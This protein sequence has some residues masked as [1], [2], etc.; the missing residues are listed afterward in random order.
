MNTQSLK[1]FC[2]SLSKRI[3]FYATSVFFLSLIV[4]LWR[5]GEG[6]LQDWDEAIYAE[7]SKNIVERNNWVTLFWGDLPWFHKP[8]LFMWST[9]ALFEIFG[10]SEF[11]A[12]AAS[13]ISGI[14]LVVTTYFLG[15]KIHSRQAG[16]LAS[17]I[18]LSSKQIIFSSRFGTTDIML[19]LFMMFS[20]YAYI[21]AQD[22][23]EHWL[24]PM[25]SA[26]ALAFMV[27]G[28]ASVFVPIAIGLL[29]VARK[30]SVK[31]L[32]S[33]HFWVGLAI[34]A[35]LVLPWHLIM[36]AQHGS[37]FLGEYIGYHVIARATQPLEGH[38]HG[39]LFYVFI[40]RNQ[41]FPWFFLVLPAVFS[42]FLVKGDSKYRKYSK[43][44]ILF[45][46]IV[47]FG[48]T[49]AGTKLPWYIVP[50]Y[51]PLAILVA[52]L[53]ICIIR[54]ERSKLIHYA[55]L[56]I[57]SGLFLLGLYNSKQIYIPPSLPIVSIVEASNL[58]SSSSPLN[59][60]LIY[61]PTPKFYSE[62]P[63]NF[64]WDSASLKDKSLCDQEIILKTE[65]LTDLEPVNFSVIYE[66][67]AYRLIKLTCAREA[68][69]IRQTISSFQ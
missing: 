29:I 38:D 18:L 8:P 57:T 12:R 48:Y 60:Y 7:V 33:R 30:E 58:E 67:N 19:T 25:F 69:A 1:L 26:F 24:I 14:G 64:I 11:S 62:R 49:V 9:A 34:A 56:S 36:L 41:F 5:L 35:L 45:S 16:F 31:I 54:A 13:A 15:K 51:P 55:T 23:H 50:I 44:L 65:N 47:F 4:F 2:A 61:E 42:P 27:K 22:D 53:L 63:T 40:L 20:I 10:I 39:Y 6:H 52:S 43:D 46:F 37:S 28:V 21:K 66:S 68:D 32:S 59:F 17:L 3:D